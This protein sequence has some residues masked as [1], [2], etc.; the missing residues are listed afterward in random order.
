ME[1]QLQTFVCVKKLENL[2]NIDRALKGTYKGIVY[3]VEM[4]DKVKIGCSNQ[5]YTRYMAL[6]RTSEKYG[7]SKIGKICI[8]PVHTNY[9]LNEKIAHQYFD[10]KRVDGTELFDITY[11]DFLKHAQKIGLKYFDETEKNSAHDDGFFDSVKRF[12]LGN[13]DNECRREQKEKGAKISKQLIELLMTYYLMLKDFKNAKPGEEFD[14]MD[15]MHGQYLMTLSE[16]DYEAVNCAL[17][18]LGITH[19][20]IELERI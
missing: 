15:T 13:S 16:E 10:S 5:P 12:V 17:C 8:S 4:G 3:C 6:K 9:R 19:N 20:V 7:N 1:K 11:N 18:D 2:K 14:E